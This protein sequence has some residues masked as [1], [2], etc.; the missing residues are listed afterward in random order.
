MGFCGRCSWKGTGVCQAPAALLLRG[1][2]PVRAG[3]PAGLSQCRIVEIKGVISSDGGQEARAA[4]E[5]Q[6][7]S[8][9][10]EKNTLGS[11]WW[12]EGGCKA[13]HC[14]LLLYPPR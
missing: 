1:G 14:H 10:M 11:C 3:I 8:T 9:G 4:R 13:V 5:L 7:Q 2:F 12:K 6:S